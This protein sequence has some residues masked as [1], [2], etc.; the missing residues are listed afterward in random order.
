MDLKTFLPLNKVVDYLNKIST[1][2]EIE[3]YSN[4]INSFFWYGKF[5]NKSIFF[6]L[7]DQS[8]YNKSMSI[9][10]KYWKKINLC[11]TM[12]YTK[13]SKKYY[14]VIYEDYRAKYK[15]VHNW[16]EFLNDSSINLDIKADVFKCIY[17]HLF[18]LAESSLKYETVTT[19]PNKVFFEGRF[20][21]KRLYKYYWLSYSAL[22]DDAKNLLGNDNLILIKKILSLSET[23]IWKKAK[24]FTNISHWDLHDLNYFLYSVN[25]KIYDVLFLDIA[26]IGRNPFLSDFVCYYWYLIYQADHIIHTYNKDFFWRQP[27]VKEKMRNLQIK[28]YLEQYFYPLINIIGCKYTWKDEFLRRL[29]LR[30]LWVYNVLDFNVVDRKKIY[31]ILIDLLHWYKDDTSLVTLPFNCVINDIN[32][33]KFY[34]LHV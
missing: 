6:K 17:G 1:T 21:K 9:H 30:I 7:M 15:K 2:I 3:S 22:L 31:L 4:S 24:T 5:K 28:M 29:I 14:L 27:R 16:I 11:E 26:T 19:Y 20:W 18:D 23:I 10:L 13:I 25:D 33:F 32:C 34:R 12:N 8:N